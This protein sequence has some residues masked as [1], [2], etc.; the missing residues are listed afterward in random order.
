MPA[1]TV[2]CCKPEPNL[3]DEC[4]AWDVKLR[5]LGAV[6]EET[7]MQFVERHQPKRNRT[8]K[9]YVQGIMKLLQKIKI[10]E[11]PSFNVVDSTVPS[12]AKSSCWFYG[13][14]SEFRV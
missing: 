5:N 2:L 14:I 7:M 10:V 1:D 9:A 11:F 13:H 6:V 4:N 3:I 12:L 8:R